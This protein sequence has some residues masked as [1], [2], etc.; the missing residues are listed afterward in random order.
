MNSVISKNDAKRRSL[1]V[2]ALVALPLSLVPAL[3]APGKPLPQA[4]VTGGSGIT[5]VD[6]LVWSPDGQRLAFAASS[7]VQIYDVKSRAQ[8][9]SRRFK[10]Q[11][12][13]DEVQGLAF[14]K[15]KTRLLVHLGGMGA[16]QRVQQWKLR[17]GSVRTVWASPE[18][19]RLLPSSR[20]LATSF[21]SQRLGVSVKDFGTNRQ[22]KYALLPPAR[23]AF[24]YSPRTASL[25]SSNW[26]F[27]PDGRLGAI[28]LYSP[29]KSR[30]PGKLLMFDASTGRHLRSIEDWGTY[31][32]VPLCF[33]RDKRTLAA[34]QREGQNQWRVQLFDTASGRT[35]SGFA[36]KG[37]LLQ[38]EF[39]PDNSRLAF[40]EL[41]GT[42]S[43]S[44]VRIYNAKTAKLEQ[45]VTD[46][47]NGIGDFEF[48]PDSR[49]LATGSTN[50]T[51]RIWRVR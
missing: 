24:G 14:F 21:D 40:A 39:S 46:A 9:A 5:S 25:Q 32:T 45:T 38:A 22:L 10:M 19:V 44:S 26:Q 8:V 43:R 35:I 29:G 13:F 33:S 48:S 47:R 4:L 34:L 7:L 20:A 51:V 30:L 28:H 27:S 50:G 17:D 41:S 3:A 12:E 1:F 49:W 11:D 23:Y 6:N 18:P 15:D 37:D 42:P 2:L 16:N 31:A 36:V